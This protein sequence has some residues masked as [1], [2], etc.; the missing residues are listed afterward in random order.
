MSD[1]RPDASI[2]G[3]PTLAFAHL[4][5]NAATSL[6][7]DHYHGELYSFLRRATRDEGAA[8]DLLQDAFLRLTVEVQ[9]G[10]T[11]ENVRAWLYTVAG[12]LVVSR[13]RRRSTVVAWLS[14]QVQPDSGQGQGESAETSFLRHDRRRSLG[15]VLEGLPT[16]ARTALLMSGQ[17]FRGVEIA[18]AIGRSHAATRTLLVRTR[19]RMRAELRALEERA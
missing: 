18:E 1:I 11:P 7:F 3:E 4:D 13:A 5:A 17:G 2:E 10:R 16:D 15:R 12:N 8:E 14:R 19:L 9:Q 6:A